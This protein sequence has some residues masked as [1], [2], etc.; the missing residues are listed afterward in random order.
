M[1]RVALVVDRGIL[2]AGHA[3][4]VRDA[5]E[6]V[7]IAV[8]QHT[9]M[10]VNPTA[11]D[12][13]A[14]VASVREK[15]VDGWVAL[16][17]GSVLDT[18]KAANL[19]CCSG[20]RLEDYLGEAVARR[21]LLPMVAIPTTAGTGSE[22]QTHA[23]IAHPVTHAKQAIGVPEAMPV[24][25]LL[26]PSLTLSM[27]PSL[28]AMSGLD[29]LGHAVETA[30]CATATDTSRALSLRAF[31]VLLKHLP[32]VL[33]EPDN[34][35]SRGHMLQAASW[36]GRA[37]HLSML[38]AAHA[39]ANPLTAHHQVPH[40][41]AVGW[42]L[43]HVI[44]FNAE[45]PT[46]N[47]IYQDLARAAGLPPDAHRLAA[48]CSALARRCLPEGLSPW[49]T[50]HPNVELMAVEAAAQWTA[51]FNPRPVDSQEMAEL[52]R[53]SLGGGEGSIH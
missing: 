3:T 33:A 15:G 53:Q 24:V 29:A 17:G 26:D 5:L 43:P 47:R 46:A 14:C 44:R 6:Q 31:P 10:N 36:A 2:A 20:G 37:I 34:L 22:V 42:M 27:P 48:E 18:A 23:L 32:R 7:G 35:T 16:G 12:V 50:P 28:T 4:T 40:G 1:R 19:L 39:L 9:L 45:D 13:D 52:Y 41:A 8:V 25:A 30:V 11:D 51:Q 21:P 49:T 38:G